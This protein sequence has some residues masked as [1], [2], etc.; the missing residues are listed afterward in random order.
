MLF[1]GRFL[2]IKILAGSEISIPWRSALRILYKL[3]FFLFKMT[4]QIFKCLNAFE[5]FI[6]VKKKRREL[7]IFD[8]ILVC[9]QGTLMNIKYGLQICLIETF[10]QR[11]MAY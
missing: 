3:H 9:F 2:N 5:K 8:L 1:Q 7:E 4:A 11:E 6:F 10:K